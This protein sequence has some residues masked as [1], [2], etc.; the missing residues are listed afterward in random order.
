MKEDSKIGWIENKL[1]DICSVKD[2]TH[3]SPKYVSDGIPFVTQKNI[4]D[5]QVNF[6]KVKLIS[7]KDHDK[8]YKRSDVEIGDILIAMIGVN[9]GEVGLVND[10]RVFSIKNVGLIKANPDI[11]MSYLLYYLK[12]DFARRYVDSHSKGGAQPFISLTKLRAFPIARPGL[13]EQKRI[14]AI[15]DQ[16]FADIDKARAT[17]ERNLKNARELFD[18]EKAAIFT[19]VAK[20]SLLKPIA[21]TCKEIFAGGDAPKHSLSKIKTNKYTIPIL[22]NAVKNN[23]L[24]GY[25]EFAR[26]T[27]PSVTLAARGSGTG[28]TEIRREAFLPIVRLIVLTPDDE[29]VNVDYLYY[30][31]KNLDI[32]RSGSAIPQLTIP[33]IKSYSV[34]VPDLT[35][36]VQVI[37]DLEKSKVS[38]E[39]LQAIYKQKIELFDELKKSILQKAF[40]GELTKSK[41]I[42][43]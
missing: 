5:G 10:S 42:A 27:E 32:L 34:P 33:M 22:A 35:T 8:F 3:D 15:L 23:G 12:S 1:S 38:I 13:E 30:A 36:Q 41:G 7:Q 20:K 28:H 25:T 19:N 40:T 29:I 39:K 21:E 2:G 18:S 26:V 17:A 24:Y 31:I 11:D 9:R 4:R 37:R 6:D 43:A 16:A 14:V